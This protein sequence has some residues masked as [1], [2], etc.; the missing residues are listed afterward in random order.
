MP[1]ITYHLRTGAVLSEDSDEDFQRLR[2]QIEGY[3]DTHESV[4]I[5]R[6]ERAP[7]GRNVRV[8]I[9]IPAEAISRVRIEEPMG[10]AGGS[11]MQHVDL[12]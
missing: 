3:L 5:E 2:D 7:D 8:A 6:L 12:P 9:L 10:D 1:T 4:V 11:A